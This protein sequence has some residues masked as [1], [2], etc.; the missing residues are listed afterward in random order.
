MIVVNFSHPLTDD[1][2]A[3]IEEKANT[4]IDRVIDVSTYVDFDTS[5]VGQ[6][7]EL[8]SSIELSITDW[9]SKPIFIVPPAFTSA[10][11][12]LIAHLQGLMGHF[13]GIVRVQRRPETVVST[14]DVVEVISL[15]VVRDSAALPRR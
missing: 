13:P 8:I 5:V 1:Q 2:R 11:V 15:D 9:Q 3:T 14:F 12:V 4:T 10:A 6:V 7:S